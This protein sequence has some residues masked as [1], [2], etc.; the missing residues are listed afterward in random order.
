MRRSVANQGYRNYST[1]LVVVTFCLVAVVVVGT[2]YLRYRDFFDYHHA[3]ANGAT[4]E[5][6]HAIEGMIVERQRLVQLFADDHTEI[7]NSVAHAPDDHDQQE[8]LAREIGR[9]FP[10][11]FAFTLPIGMAPH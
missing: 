8:R 11:Y 2:T 6:G 5:L 1:L 3:I 10:D 4:G 7:L 9:M